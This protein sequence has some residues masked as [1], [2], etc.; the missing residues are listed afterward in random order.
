MM[1][2]FKSSLTG[3]IVGIISLLVGL[4]GIIITVKTMKS[5]KRIEEDL[6]NAQINALD[7]KR[8]HEARSTTLVKLRT[9]RKA[10]QRE[11]IISINL[12]NDVLTI[13]NDLKGY[14]NILSDM[15][16]MVIEESGKE[17]K[18]ITSSIQ[19]TK[20]TND[21]VIDFD[22]AVADII[23]MLSKGEYEL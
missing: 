16:Q 11:G 3:N 12:C 7:K 19:N 14:S 5:A 21:N 2:V 15:D 6:K 1:G 17:L 9:K 10:A 13:I 18:R 22:K 4:V 20:C 8:F 23:N